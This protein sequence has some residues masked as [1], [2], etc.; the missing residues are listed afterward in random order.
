MNSPAE[1]ID[2]SRQKQK[3]LHRPEKG[4]IG[5]CYRTAIACVL[6]VPRD[7]VPHFVEQAGWDNEEQAQ[8]LLR[9]W[10]AERGIR[11]VS[12]PIHTGPHDHDYGLRCINVWNPGARFIFSGTS[13]NGTMHCVVARNGAIEWDPAIDNSGIVGPDPDGFYWA[14]YFFR[15]AA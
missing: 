4:E 12:F 14:E 2:L 3:Y 8:E 9:E 15:G 10:L 11:R 5:D 6:G 13:R 7:S 1:T